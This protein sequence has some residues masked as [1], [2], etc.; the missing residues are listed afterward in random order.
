[1]T[2]NTKLQIFSALAMA[3]GVGAICGALVS[4]NPWLATAGI[5]VFIFGAIVGSS[6]TTPR[7]S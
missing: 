4:T 2:F 7:H 1:M 5:G 6:P 3:V